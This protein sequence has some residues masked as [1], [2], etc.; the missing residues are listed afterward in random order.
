MLRWSLSNKS[1]LEK[2]PP[3]SKLLLLGTSQAGSGSASAGTL[4][5]SPPQPAP[6]MTPHGP[7]QSSPASLRSRCFP[8]GSAPGLGRTTSVSS[9]EQSLQTR[10]PGTPPCPA[11][12][13]APSLEAAAALGCVPVL[14]ERQ[15]LHRARGAGR[16]R[17]GWAV[18]MGYCP[19]N[20]CDTKEPTRDKASPETSFPAE[21]P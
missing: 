10:A 13:A 4:L 3:A 15:R 14:W 21:T 9:S 2:L 19:G 20:C 6:A 17:P 1:H 11:D 12:A 7:V 8:S 18:G 5:S 16:D